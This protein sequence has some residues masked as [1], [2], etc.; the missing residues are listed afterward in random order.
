MLVEQLEQCRKFIARNRVQCAD[1]QS[2]GKLACV[3]V[4]Q[5]YSVIE[6]TQRP[7]DVFSELFS[8]SREAHVATLFFEQG[9]AQFALE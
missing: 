7:I 8:I 9:N 6:L 3:F 4:C 5:L 2:A 1:F